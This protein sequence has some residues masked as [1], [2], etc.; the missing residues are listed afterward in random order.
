MLTGWV[1]AALAL[2]GL[3]KSFGAKRAVDGLNLQ[4]R[5]GCMFGLVG[6]NGAGKTTT[7]SVATGLRTAC[8]CSTG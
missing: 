3:T 8:G 2:I 5:R 6:P 7:L 1:N 4:V